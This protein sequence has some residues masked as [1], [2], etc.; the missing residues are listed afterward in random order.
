MSRFSLFGRKESAEPAPEKKGWFG[1]L[2]A[3]LRKS[4]EALTG[5][6]AAVFTRNRVYLADANRIAGPHD[7]RKV[8]GFVQA[9]GQD[10]EVWLSTG[11]DSVDSL[12]P[13]G[14]H[15]AAVPCP[16]PGGSRIARKHCR[17]VLRDCNSSNA[18]K[19]SSRPFSIQTSGRPP[20]SREASCV[21]HE[22][23]T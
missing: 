1:R 2:A 19:T 11:K 18:G 14:R 9:L 22:A 5:N 10:R 8:A 7:S 23:P 15:A 12:P 13:P 20:A 21:A 17:M 4:S 3:G 16:E 6:V